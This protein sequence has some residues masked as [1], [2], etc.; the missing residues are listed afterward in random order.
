MIYTSLEDF[1]AKA[2][3]CQSLTRQEERSYALRM[4]QGDTDARQRLIEGYLPMVAAHIRRLS[5]N[6]QQFALVIYC[7]HAL[8]QAVDSFD[9]L[10]DSE[11]F[12]HRLSWYLRQATAQ[13]IVR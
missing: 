9:F 8:E 6:M 4:A 11:T 13:Y 10:Q 1:Y 2:A 12:T 3:S 5:A 7:V